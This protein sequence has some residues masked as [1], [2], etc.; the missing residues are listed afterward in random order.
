MGDETECE[1]ESEIRNQSLFIKI[2]NIVERT[3]NEKFK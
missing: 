1:L 3:K 2:K